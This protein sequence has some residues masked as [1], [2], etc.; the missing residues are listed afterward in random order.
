MDAHGDALAPVLADATLSDSEELDG[1]ADASGLL[2][3]FLGDAR[4]ALDGDVVNADARVEGQGRQ[5]GA[6]GGGVEALDVRGGVGLGETKVLRLL[7]SIL[8]AQPLGAHRVQ[9]EVGRAV[10]DA[11][12]GRDAVAGEGLA[13][14]VNDGDGARDGRLVVEVGTV[15]RGGLVQ[16]GTVRGQEGL[17]AGDDRDALV[18]GAQHEGARG[19]NAADQLDDEVHVVDRL[20]RV[21]RQQLAVDRSVTRGIHIA[22]EDAAHLHFR[23]RASGEILA[24]RLK[25]AND[26]ATDGSGS[27]NANSKDRTGCRHR[28]FS[29]LWDGH[30][31]QCRRSK[32]LP[33]LKDLGPTI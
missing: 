30:C 26:L 2:H 25:N 14:A 19:L 24:A 27:K 15:G 21:G 22:D 31:Y 1:V 28:T 17:V 20:G 18:E 9:D 6:L 29:P 32:P 4:D 11:H 8:V 10:H 5:D 13:Q 7:E 33:S 23:A 16:L 3:V 12:H